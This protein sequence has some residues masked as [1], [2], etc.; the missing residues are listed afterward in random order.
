MEYVA[1][2]IVLHVLCWG[3][4]GAAL[5]PRAGLPNWAGAL[6]SIGL[7]CI[8]SLVLAG[9]AAWGERRRS[10]A[11][12]S[13]A[14]LA[15]GWI[16]VAAGVLILVSA[17]LTWADVTVAGRVG[18]VQDN[19]F[20]LSTE[21]LDFV[22]VSVSIS[23]VL[24]AVCSWLAL[25]FRA[26][27]WLVGAAF[28]AWTP[29]AVALNLILIEAPVDVAMNKAT[30]AGQVLDEQEL[31]DLGVSGQ[32]TV[33][34]GAY[35]SAFA[36]VA[37][38]TWA[39]VWAMRRADYSSGLAGAPIVERGPDRPGWSTD[40]AGPANSSGSDWAGGDWAGGGTPSP[41][42]AAGADWIEGSNTGDDWAGSDGWHDSGKDGT[43]GGWR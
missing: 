6:I 4:I 8:G 17:F 27:E 15:A 18:S 23:G 21:D 42:S 40:P 35:L 39:F 7:P 29:A 16:G 32:Y 28:F 12:T 31:A 41:G 24:V 2:F 9:M 14:W 43:P 13:S 26:R 10:G 30:K 37:A 19:I 25:R 38:L 11:Q 36:A 1:V 3:A 22:P 34:A 5:S 33:G 20:S